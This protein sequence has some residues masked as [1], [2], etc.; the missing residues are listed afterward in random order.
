[1][2]LAMSHASGR[3]NLRLV[4]W[5]FLI[6]SVPVAIYFYR[7]FFFPDPYFYEGDGSGGLRMVLLAVKIGMPI[8]YTALI[9]FY[10]LVRTDRV[11]LLSVTV[12][13]IGILVA[14]AAGGTAGLYLYS[15]QPPLAHLGA[16][17][18]YLQ[19]APHDLK[20]RTSP[21][22]SHPLRIFCLGGSTTEWKD[23]TGSDWPSRVEKLLN[24]ASPQRPYEVYNAGREWYTTLH[25]ELNYLSNLRQ[26]KPDV[27][28]VMQSINDLLHNADFSYF[29]SG[30]FREDYRH[31][32][33]P[34]SNVLRRPSFFGML[35]EKSAAAWYF[36]GRE[37]V[38]TAMFPGLVSYRR[39]I[40]NLLDI[41][42]LDGTTVV[43]MSEPF[44]FKKEMS[45]EERRALYMLNREAIGE[46]KQWDLSTALT[47]MEYYNAQVE[48]IARERGVAFIDLEKAIPKS[49]EYFRDDVHYTDKAFPLIASTVSAELS[50]IL[51]V[52]N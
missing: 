44:L 24:A 3:R 38:R 35:R 36:S 46:K 32:Y 43:L 26:Y 18:P 8:L 9:A 47:G 19:L 1:M 10:F 30:P 17:H 34:L 6:L 28:V 7:G 37:V 16:F 21:P 45:D 39:N 49:L 4:D 11:A 51:A 23:S 5:A 25:T 41:A 29:S 20:I 40:E 48:V 27:I 13:A 31:F 2:A 52:P 14:L 33:G 50:K 12:M 42:K 15:A 22:S